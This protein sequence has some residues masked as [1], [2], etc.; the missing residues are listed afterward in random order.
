[1]PLP[2][3]GSRVTVRATSPHV[4]LAPCSG[5]FFPIDKPKEVIVTQ[6]VAA[7]LADGSLVDV[8]ASAEPTKE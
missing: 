5:R 7:R 1:M 6:H 2:T 8:S 3:F 4:E